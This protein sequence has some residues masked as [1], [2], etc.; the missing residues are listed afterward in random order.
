MFAS[1]VCFSGP[2]FEGAKK[3]AADHFA[4]QSEGGQHSASTLEHGNGDPCTFCEHVT[5]GCHASACAQVRERGHAH[6]D[7][8]DPFGVGV[9]LPADISAFFMVEHFA[10]LSLPLRAP[11]P[12]GSSGL[13][14]WRDRKGP[15]V[16]A[17]I[18]FFIHFFDAFYIRYGAR[19]RI[20]IFNILRIGKGRGDQYLLRA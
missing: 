20:G 6:S 3:A 16:A 19:N 17:L 14:L 18:A 8:K 10:D 9:M 13:Q 5:R 2:L 7:G 1:V 15:C 4:G 12:N 11:R